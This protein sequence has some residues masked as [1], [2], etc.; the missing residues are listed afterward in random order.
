MDGWTNSKM[1]DERGSHNFFNNDNFI[2]WLLPCLIKNFISDQNEQTD[3][4][5]ERWNS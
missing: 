1:A 5:T 4:Q 2:H 3:G